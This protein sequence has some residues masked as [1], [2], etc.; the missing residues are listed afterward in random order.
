MSNHEITINK[1]VYHKKERDQKSY[2]QPRVPTI[3]NFPRTNHN[4][5]N[6]VTGPTSAE[7]SIHTQQTTIVTYAYKTPIWPID[8][9]AKQLYW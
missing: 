9:S 2:R 1:T 3:V 4:N 6:K 5:N 8:I 7:G